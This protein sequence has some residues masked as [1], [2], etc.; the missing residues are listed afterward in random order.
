VQV[1]GGIAS[2]CSENKNDTTTQLVVEN[3]PPTYDTIMM[4]FVKV[5]SY[6]IFICGLHC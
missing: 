5:V 3:W 2:V 1:R 4:Y 6:V